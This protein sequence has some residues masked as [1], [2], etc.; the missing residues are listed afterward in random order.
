[1]NRVI[2]YYYGNGKGKTSAA[3]GACIRAAGAGMQCAVVQFLKNGSSSE[4]TMLRSLGIPVYACSF[5]GVRFFREMTESEQRIVISEHN[6]NLRRLIGMQA[7]FMVL[8]ELGDALR[9]NAVDRSLV[10]RI[11][12]LPDCEIILTG[13]KPVPEIMER[14]DYITEFRSVA[15]PYQDGIAA[16]KGIEY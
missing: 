15:H 7:D 13:H 2:H 5:Q 8:D 14:A 1:M 10:N 6:A 16:R 4:I 12:D 3:N 11:L 9:R